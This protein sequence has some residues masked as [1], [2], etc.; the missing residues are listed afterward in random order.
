MKKHNRG[1]TFIWGVG[2][3]VLTLVTVVFPLADPAAMAAGSSSQSVSPSDTSYANRQKANVYFKKAE[4][5][6]KQ[7]KYDKAAELYSKA[8]EIDSEYAEAF[9]NLG[10]SLRKQGDF[11]RAIAAY[12]RAIA[13]K[14]DLTEAHEY[15]GEAFAEMGEFGLAE[16][17]LDVLRKLDP[18]EAEELAEFI[19]QQKSKP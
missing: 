16:K 7:G 6:Q 9:S 12:R 3:V 8:V 2:A 13:L 19:E 4:A 18:E 11:D 15:I 1:H 5:Y 17:H 10:F 14:P